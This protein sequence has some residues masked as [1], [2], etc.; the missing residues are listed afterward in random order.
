M[1]KWVLQLT[2]N[3]A[4]FIATTCT[5]KHSVTGQGWRVRG[6]DGQAGVL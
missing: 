3:E 2:P 6:K 1:G 4:R 5:S